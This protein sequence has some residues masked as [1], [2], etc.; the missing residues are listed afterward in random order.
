MHKSQEEECVQ[1]QIRLT[2][3]KIHPNITNK[4]V[5][6]TIKIIAFNCIAIEHYSFSMLHALKSTQNLIKKMKH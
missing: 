3:T 4:N 6:K 5:N 1:Q 2:T